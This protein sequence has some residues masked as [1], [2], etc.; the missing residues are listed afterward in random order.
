M[1]ECNYS[2]INCTYPS[3]AKPACTASKDCDINVIYNVDMPRV[4]T[5]IRSVKMSQ[6]SIDSF[7]TASRIQEDKKVIVTRSPKKLPYEE[8]G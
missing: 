2:K 1:N 8:K 6:T 7:I 5:P 3:L 4:I